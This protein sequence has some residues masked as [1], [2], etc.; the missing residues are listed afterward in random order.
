MQKLKLKT[1]IKFAIRVYQL[2]I[3]TVLPNSC[4]FTPTCSEYAIQ[5]ID[6]FG[7]GIGLFLALKR[8]LRCNPFSAGGY[9]P[10][11]EGSF[12]AKARSLLGMRLPRLVM[13]P[14]NDDGEVSRAMTGGEERI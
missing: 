3:G 13:K 8:L 5:A 14:R 1:P 9:D 6:R 11:P 7:I 2:T 4:R 12:R 10:V